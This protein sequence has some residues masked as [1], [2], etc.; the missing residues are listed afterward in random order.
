[1]KDTILANT[2][3][4]TNIFAKYTRVPIFVSV[5]NYYCSSK[6]GINTVPIG[7]FN[8]SL[9]SQVSLICNLGLKVGINLS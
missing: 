4:H 9:G 1:M 7:S 2:H 5:N 3:M 6:P 8:Q